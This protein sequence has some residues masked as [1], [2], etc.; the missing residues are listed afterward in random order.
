V[1]TIITAISHVS[2]LGQIIT[3]AIAAAIVPQA[4]ATSQLPRHELRLVSCR[5]SSGVNSVFG[6]MRETGAMTLLF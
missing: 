5:H 2:G 4:C 1:P 6:S 3:S